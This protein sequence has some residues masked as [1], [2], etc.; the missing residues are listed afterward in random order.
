M[1]EGE[2]MLFGCN[3]SWELLEL[4][5]ED[6]NICDYIKIGAFGDTEE[7]LEIAYN[8]KP[9]LIHGFGWFERGGMS[10]TNII[11]INLMNDLLY[12][13]ESPFLG[14]HALAYKKDV[15]LIDN[16]LEHMVQTFREVNKKLNIPLTIENMDF[17]T[18]YDYETTILET[19][20]PEFLTSLINETEL[21]LLLDTSH[22]LVSAYQ[23][24]IDIYD[25]LECLPL[26]RVKEIHITG[27]FLTK[28]NGYK[29][30]HD[31]MNE[32]DYEIARFLATHPRIVSSCNLE[33]V[34]LEYGGLSNTDKKAIKHQLLELKQIFK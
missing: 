28:D 33:I 32:T 23:L 22:A 17:S 14:M 7:F 4:I 8:L 19:V 34:T 10:S 2:L 18:T 12:R 27:S 9:L 1:G 6:S 26:E 30:I 3:F 24:G 20:K 13:Y 16:L 31:I 11:D 15:I 21:L 29:D 25:Y 5:Y